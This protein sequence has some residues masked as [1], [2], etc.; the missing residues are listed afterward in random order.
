MIKIQKCEIICNFI[1]IRSRHLLVIGI[2]LRK[3]ILGISISNFKDA[4]HGHGKEQCAVFLLHFSCAYL[5]ET[6]SVNMVHHHNLIIKGD[7]R[8]PG[9]ATETKQQISTL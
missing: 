4:Q 6:F 9:A 1:S 8:S 2:R 7:T 3:S 5:W